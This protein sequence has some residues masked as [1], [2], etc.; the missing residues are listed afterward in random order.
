[1]QR[2]VRIVLLVLLLL[3]ATYVGTF[4][5]WWLNGSHCTYLDGNVRVRGVLFRFDGV[6][7]RTAPVWAPAVWFVEHVLKYE[8]RGRLVGPEDYDVYERRDPC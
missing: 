5:Y 3:A 2:V 6:Y 4:S 7:E 8:R 1:M